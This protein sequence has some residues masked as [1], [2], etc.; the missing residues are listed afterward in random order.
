MS[1][2]DDP[3]PSSTL[4]RRPDGRVELTLNQMCLLLA[5]R[6]LPRHRAP[7]RRLWTEA[8][9]R[10]LHQARANAS[11]RNLYLSAWGMPPVLVAQR[12]AGRGIVAEATRLGRSLPAQF[13]RIWI[14]GHGEWQGFARLVKAVE[15]RQGRRRRRAAAAPIGFVRGDLWGGPLDGSH[16]ALRVPGRDEIT[17]SVDTPDGRRLARYRKLSGSDGEPVFVPSNGRGEPIGPVT[18]TVI[19]RLEGKR[20]IRYR[21]CGMV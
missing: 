9:M 5:L 1:H 19:P 15:E 10:Y 7:N 18:E 17:L 21:F 13:G 8:A 12:P 2:F 20:G 11:F 6:D 14:T 16:V 3:S 4:A